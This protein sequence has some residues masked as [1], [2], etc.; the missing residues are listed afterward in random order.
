MSGEAKAPSR[1]RCFP[2][3]TVWLRVSSEPELNQTERELR[4]GAK[5]YGSGMCAAADLRGAFL[6]D[7]L[8]TL[9]RHPREFP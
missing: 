3:Q 2:R 9:N 4:E 5:H 8:K 6:R 7:R 1:K